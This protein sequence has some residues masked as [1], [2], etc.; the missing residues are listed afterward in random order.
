MIFFKHQ[1]KEKMSSVFSKHATTRSKYCVFGYMRNMEQLLKLS[2]IPVVIAYLCLKYYAIPEMF[3]KFPTK[4]FQTTKDKLTIMNKL[5]APYNQHCIYLYQ[6]ID[7]TSK[8]IIKW[9]FKIN[10]LY[11]INPFIHGH[12][13]TITFSL[14]FKQDDINKGIVQ[15]DGIYF[16]NE[17]LFSKINFKTGDIVIL[18]LDLIKREFTYQVNDAQEIHLQHPGSVVVTKDVKYKMAMESL[19]I[20][21][22]VTIQDFSIEN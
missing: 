6:W 21:N 20:G 18:K 16:S 9:T 22:S 3:D 14:G 17:G 7:S 13:K 19:P 1:K 12:S 5:H 10:R 8:S 15:T 2:S 4:Y 11:L